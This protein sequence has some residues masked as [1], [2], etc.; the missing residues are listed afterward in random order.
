[1]S[2]EKHLC[3]YLWPPAAQELSLC[4]KC[5]LKYMDSP[6]AAGASA[7]SKRAV[8]RK[9]TEGRSFNIH[10]IKYQSPLV[11]AHRCSDPSAFSTHSSYVPLMDKQELCTKSISALVL[12]TI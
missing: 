8:G 11:T 9:Q 7:M 5:S 3:S 1:M 6:R 12:T 10:Q 4:W 2:S